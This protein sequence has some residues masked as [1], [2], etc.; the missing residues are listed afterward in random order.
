MKRVGVV[1]IIGAALVA[2][3][4]FNAGFVHIVRG[5][6]VHRWSG[7]QICTKLEWTLRNTFMNTD[8]YVGQPELVAQLD[9]KAVLALIRCG[10]VRIPPVPSGPPAPPAPRGLVLMAPAG[11]TLD[12]ILLKQTRRESRRLALPAVAARL[13]HQ[14]LVTQLRALRAPKRRAEPAPA[15]AAVT[16]LSAEGLSLL[17]REDPLATV[18]AG[19]APLLI[20]QGGK[21]IQVSLLRDAIAGSPPRPAATTIALRWGSGGSGNCAA[22]RRT[23]SLRLAPDRSPAADCGAS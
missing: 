13:R 4:V 1:G 8:D 12:R 20:C 7:I 16:G 15:A 19:R 6:K 5:R 14:R 23:R 2:A 17:L 21:D 11:R 18:R 10:V 9:A 3:V 22:Q